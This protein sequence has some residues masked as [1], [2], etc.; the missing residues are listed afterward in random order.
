[1]A[2]AHD[3]P[4]GTVQITQADLATFAAGLCQ[5]ESAS[6]SYCPCG[7][8]LFLLHISYIMSKH[9]KIVLQISSIVMHDY[10]GDVGQQK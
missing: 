9:S 10:C 7:R 1:M 8:L 5:Y 3:N 6:A 4:E 2:I